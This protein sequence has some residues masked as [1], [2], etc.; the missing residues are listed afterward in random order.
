M[1]IM[2]HLALGL[3]AIGLVLFSSF[4]V[5]TSPADLTYTSTC[6][7]V[8]AVN[9]TT[10]VENEVF[11]CDG[12]LRKFPEFTVV[13]L[14]VSADLYLSQ[15]S[16]QIV[17]IEASERDLKHLITK[18]KGGKLYIKFESSF[19]SHDDIKIYV[20][21]T[22]IDGVEVAGS[23]NIYAKDKIKAD[24]L[25]ITIAGSGN[26]KFKE[27]IVDNLETK[28][29]GSGDIY[30]AG[31]SVLSTHEVNIAGSGDVNAK[32][33]MAKSAEVNIAG[34]GNCYLGVENSL[35]VNIA[36]SG[37]VYYKG[38]PDVETNVFGS[39]DVEKI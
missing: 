20:T 36:G 28:I 39:G 2:K 26:M 14:A 7:E 10:N 34:S 30:V 6:T 21:M 31:P 9:S 27:L 38:N 15:G 8:I 25:E 19:R 23:G 4:A 37:D 1:N 3:M 17:R 24:N 32:G 18:V 16:K 13:E 12:E 5:I 29:A 35:E 11:Q 33:L 22:K